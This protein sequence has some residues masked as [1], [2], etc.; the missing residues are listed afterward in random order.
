MNYVIF[1]TETSDLF[2]KDLPLDHPNQARIVQLACVLIDSSFNEIN[3]F[4]TLIKPD[5]WLISPGAQAVHGISQKDCETYG[6]PIQ[7]ALSI[8]DS[9]MNQSNYQVA[10]NSRFD[11][12][13]IDVEQSCLGINP[14]DWSN[15]ICTMMAMTPICRLHNPKRANTFKWP[16][17][18]EAFHFCY[19]RTFS[20]AHDALIDVR[21]CKDV[22][23]WLV[24]NKQ[25]ILLDDTI[26]SSHT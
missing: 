8:F 3:I 23:K 9:F 6:I 13:M 25:I 1:D 4:S 19:G 10:H 14:K 22:F 21:G 15:V 26:E 20:D 2:K 18:L 16:K 5:N 7:I 17:L 12:Q 24:E 11:T